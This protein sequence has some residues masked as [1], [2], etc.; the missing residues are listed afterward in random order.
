MII[1]RN[2]CFIVYVYCFIEIFYRYVVWSIFDSVDILL[3][4]F[5][6]VYEV[7]VVD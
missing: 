2:D 4:V 3:F 5:Y 1:L 7:D 6:L